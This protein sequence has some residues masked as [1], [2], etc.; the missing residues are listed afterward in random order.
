MSLRSLARIARLTLLTSTFGGL[1]VGPLQ[2]Q[3]LRAGSRGDTNRPDDPLKPVTAA[4]Y[5][6]F[7]NLGRGKLSPDGR[8][9]AVPIR[10][11]NEENELRIHRTDVDSVVVV[12]YGSIPLFSNVVSSFEQL[13]PLII[14]IF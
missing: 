3:A 2:A 10:R 13:L 8:W 12:P 5:G 11:V 9:L 14:V 6:K 4:D 7:E 1:L